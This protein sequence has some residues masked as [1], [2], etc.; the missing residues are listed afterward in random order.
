M[1]QLAEICFPFLR[2]NLR[3]LSAVIID[4]HLIDVVKLSS[5]PVRNLHTDRCLADTR[6]TDEHDVFL[7]QKHIFFDLRANRLRDRPPQKQLCRCDS[8]S[9]EHAQTADR[10]HPGLV[11]LTQEIGAQRVV[12][13]VHSPLQPCE[14]A[15]IERRLS[16][17]R[18]HADRRCIDEDLRI[19][20][21]RSIGII[22]VSAAADDGHLCRAQIPQHTLYGLGG[23][24]AAKDQTVSA[25]HCHA[26]LTQQSAKA[27]I[28]GV[29]PDQPLTVPYNGVDRADLARLVG[30]CVAVW[31]YRLLIGDCHI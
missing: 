30:Q 22:H 2:K 23:A 4:N 8:L 19:L 18:V 20:L 27:R 9:D 10:F 28:I 16:V 15:R 26:V 1:L 12:N 17:V 11:C 14:A 29:V 7:S 31:D 6:H 3:D 5:H 21:L 24:T 25:A 13:H